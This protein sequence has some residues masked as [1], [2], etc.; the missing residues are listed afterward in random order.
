MRV[1]GAAGRGVCPGR[2]RRLP[3]CSPPPPPIIARNSHSHLLVLNETLIFDSPRFPHRGLLLDTARHFLPLGVIE[4]RVGGGG[5][6]CRGRVSCVCATSSPS[7]SSRCVWVCLSYAWRVECAMGV[8]RPGLALRPFTT[9]TTTTIP[10]RPSNHTPPPPT[11]T[12]T[13]ACMHACR[14]TLTRWQ[15]PSS[16]CCTGTLWMTNHSPSRCAWVCGGW[17]GGRAGGGVGGGGGDLWG[18]SSLQRAGGVIPPT[19]NTPTHPAIPPPPPPTHAHPSERGPAPA[20][21][22]GLVAERAVHPAGRGARR[23]VRARA[24][25]EGAPGV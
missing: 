3:T 17:V 11:H 8:L 23:G 16:T 20:G 13:H 19:P 5:C 6:V 14:R 24:G 21:G 25:G 2:C 15:P 4:V 10:P 7:A 18:E 9:T 1:G 12:H 22:G